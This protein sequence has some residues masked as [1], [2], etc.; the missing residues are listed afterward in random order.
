M[1]HKDLIEV[2]HMFRK[3]IIQH[4]KENAE[5]LDARRPVQM[6]DPDRIYN[7]M[8]YMIMRHKYGE[9][10]VYDLAYEVPPEPTDKE[11]GAAN[12]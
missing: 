9:S 6:S 7:E 5:E 4:W 12:V 8:I 2:A 10:I 11:R 1:K 3:E